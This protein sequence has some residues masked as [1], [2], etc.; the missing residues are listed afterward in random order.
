MSVQIDPTPLTDEQRRLFGSIPVLPALLRLN[1]PAA[2]GGVEVRPEAEQVGEIVGIL[3]VHADLGDTLHL[4]G[5]ARPDVEDGPS[6]GVGPNV[7]LSEHDQSIADRSIGLPAELR[8][9]PVYEFDR[10]V[11]GVRMAEGARIA[12]AASLTEAVA[13][14]SMLFPESPRSTFS[15]ASDGWVNHDG[16]EC[17]FAP[18]AIL[19][20]RFGDGEDM[21]MMTLHEGHGSWAWPSHGPDSTDIVAYRNV[22]FPW[23][24]KSNVG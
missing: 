4:G 8:D 3:D 17:P 2:L 13:A 19:D 11:D 1:L 15:Y 23:G 18:G 5:Q 7:V 20:V 21:L 10:Y 16:S 24:R 14:A 6:L 22:R 9:A 12:K